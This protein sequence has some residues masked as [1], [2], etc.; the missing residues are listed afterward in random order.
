MDTQTNKMELKKEL[1]QCWQ[2]QLETVALWHENLA[3]TLEGSGLRELVLQQHL[4][5]FTL[6]HVEDRARRKDVDGAIIARCKYEIDTLNQQRNDLIEQVDTWLIK[7]I[8]TFL[9]ANAL[10]TYN[11]E[12]IG[13]ALD[14][15]SILSLKIFHMQEQTERTDAGAAHKAGCMDK[16]AILREQHRDLSHSVLEL[17]DEY[18][19]GTKQPKVYFQ[20]KMYNDP[21]LNPE[22]YT[23]EMS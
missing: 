5:N 21:S 20:F 10:A 1:K 3:E 9:P 23:H 19:A 8:R 18:A 12:T 4:R 16:L 15:L 22:L 6:W 11:T 14:R 2:A 17:V 7:R 13:S